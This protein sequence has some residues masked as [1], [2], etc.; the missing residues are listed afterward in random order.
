[1]IIQRR[2]LLGFLTGSALVNLWPTV[3]R[4][5][6]ETDGLFDQLVYPPLD[7][8]DNPEP[9]GYREATEKQKQ[10]M[11]DIVSATPKGP[12]PIDIAQWFVDQYSKKDPEAISQWPVPASW[13]PLIVEFF[14]VTSYRANNDMIPW[15]AAFVNWCIERSGR[16]G[17]RNAASQ[18]F[19]FLK[20]FKKI[21]DPQVGDL[22]VFTCYDKISGK[23]LGLGHVAFVK[24]KPA[25]GTIKVVGGN[26]TSENRSSI[27]SE[28]YFSTKDRDVRRHVGGNY[29]ICNMKVNSYIR[30]V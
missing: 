6:V 4:A 13:N 12:R 20:E 16:D 9:F 10:K 19:L 3:S 1:M 27:I 8:I 28:R 2:A 11:R 5:G 14:S 15:C 17:S 25:N 26:Q 29:I 21:D 24:E 18:S 22:V 7:A 30:I 23:S